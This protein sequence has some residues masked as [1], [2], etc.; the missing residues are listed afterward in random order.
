MLVDSST[1]TT[2]TTTIT[3]TTTSTNPSRIRPSD[4]LSTV[5]A[6]QPVH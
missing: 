2:T 4:Q 5:P 1:S 6:C 3:T